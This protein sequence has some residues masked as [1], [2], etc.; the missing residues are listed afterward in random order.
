MMAFLGGIGG[1]VVF[2]ILPTLG[3]RMGLSAF[4]IGLILA[5][6][7]IVRVGMN[8]L[9]GTLVDRF[10]G[11]GVVA[12]GLFIEGVGTLGYIAAL[13]FAA[14]A[15]WFLAGRVVWGV[16]SS[17][18]FVGAVAAV[19][20][21][22]SSTNRG[23]LVAR[24]RSAIS[25]GVPGGLVLGGLVT[26]FFSAD[27]AFLAAL[28]LSTA[29]GVAALIGIPR[30]Q[31]VATPDVGTRAPWRG[32]WSILR[33]R[34][35]LGIWFYAALVSFAVQG[36]LLAT[37]VVLVERRGI[38]IAGF[39][40]EGS[41]GLM[42]AILMLAYA[43][44][45]LLI[46]RRID[47]LGR[48]TR[49]LVATIALLIGGYLLLAFS[50]SLALVIVAL[51]A[52]GIGTGSIVIPLLTLIGD[53]VEP[54]LRGRATAIYQVASDI[55]STAGPILGLMLGVR[56]GFFAIYAGIAVLFVLSLPAA[57]ALVRTERRV[58]PRA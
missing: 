31:P 55:G 15:A 37:L 18:L 56:L 46:G 12:A 14:P 35:L 29:T 41:A 33:Q 34:R 3:L 17:L 40:A 19:L 47:A 16:G 2:P 30:L 50:P 32:L 27:A 13:H 25:L 20:A 5:A 4:M 42:L 49:L 10:G 24:T 48:R 57:I 21:A 11:R 39:G 53:L 36:V 26:E 38:S 7:R 8:P 28:I 23:R 22:S 51:V 6:N 9:T 52:I 58:L 1:G 44:T 54:G 45:S 43:G